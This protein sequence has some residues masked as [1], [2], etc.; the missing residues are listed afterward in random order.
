MTILF[1]APLR[2][3]AFALAALCLPI[4]ANATMPD[5]DFV[6]LC[7]TGT[8]AQVLQALKN[9]ANAK[10]RDKDGFRALGM[11]AM[12]DSDDPEAVFVVQALLDAG[13][14][15]N[16]RDCDGETALMKAAEYRSDIRVVRAL[17]AA[18]AD[19]NVRNRY[20][21][22]PLREAAGYARNLPVVQ[23]LLAA[24]AQ[25][26]ARN[27]TTAARRLLGRRSVT[28]MFRWLKHFW[29]R[30]RMQ[31][32]AAGM[33]PRHL[34]RRRSSVTTRSWRLFWMRARTKA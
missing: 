12:R 31:M 33:V 20:G 29:M 25:V 27:G 16:G 15:V 7:E 1:P 11:A 17:L 28:T 34:C 9:G 5:T 32:H 6:A 26:D 3:C 22:T 21:S 14:D 10:A 8:A 24:G 2:R 23:A 13:A 19:A 4:L 30:A 18:G